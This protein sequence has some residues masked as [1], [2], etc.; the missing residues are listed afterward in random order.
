MQSVNINEALLKAKLS[1]RQNIGRIKKLQR[2]K[3][4][5]YVESKVILIQVL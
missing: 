3:F 5:G 2:T 1:Y 4:S